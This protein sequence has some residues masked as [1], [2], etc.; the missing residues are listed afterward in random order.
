MLLHHLKYL[1]VQALV[2]WLYVCKYNFDLLEHEF[3]K[4]LLKEDTIITN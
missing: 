4:D 1:T 2:D 3:H